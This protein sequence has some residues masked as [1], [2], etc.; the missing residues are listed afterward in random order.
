MIERDERVGQRV[1]LGVMRNG[2][3]SHSDLI[4]ICYDL[5][6]QLVFPSIK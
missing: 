4:F 1:F 2:A 3:L 6:F 5:R